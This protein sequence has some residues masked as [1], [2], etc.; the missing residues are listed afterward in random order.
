MVGK[1][2]EH[3]MPNEMRSRLRAYFSFKRTVNKSEDQQQLIEAMSPNL[4]VQVSEHIHMKWLN[5]LPI[6]ADLGGELC[7]YTSKLLHLT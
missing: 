1:Q 6:F 2:R 3:A 7:Y 5:K 4:R